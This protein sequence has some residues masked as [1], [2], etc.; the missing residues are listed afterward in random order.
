MEGSTR[1][2]KIRRAFERYSV[3][4]QPFDDLFKKHGITSAQYNA[5]RILRGHGKPVSVYQIGEQ[6]VTRKS[7]LPR[8]VDRLVSQGFAEKNRCESDRRVVW[9]TLTKKGKT[10][11]K[12]IDVPL[13]ELHR[14]QLKHLSR[15]QLTQ[16][17]ELLW[18]ARN[19]DAQLD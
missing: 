1:C 19:P 10:L 13:D 3:L 6:M 17:S 15:E 9:V 18:L 5:L 8:L 14:D 16:L 11:L 2:A 7:D 12:R 4:S